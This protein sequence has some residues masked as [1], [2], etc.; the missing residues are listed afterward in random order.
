MIITAKHTSRFPGK[1]NKERKALIDMNRCNKLRQ[2]GFTITAVSLRNRWAAIASLCS[3]QFS[4][5]QK[6][7]YFL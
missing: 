4:T 7:L 2:F 6:L 3:V 1:N 5:K